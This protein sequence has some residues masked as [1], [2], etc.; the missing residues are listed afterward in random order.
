MT[1][2]DIEMSYTH[3]TSKLPPYYERCTSD[4][5]VVLGPLGVRKWPDNSQGELLE[6]FGNHVSCKVDF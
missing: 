4:V 5:G 6:G 1:T 3:V 2:F